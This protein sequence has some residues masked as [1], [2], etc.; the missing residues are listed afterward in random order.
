M[1]Q[2]NS[3]HDRR[4][5]SRIDF[6]HEV[7]LVNPASG[8]AYDGAF[9]DISLQGML[10]HSDPLPKS[11]DHLQGTLLLGD[12]EVIIS[13]VVLWSRGEQGAAI[14][15]H[16]LDLESFSHL[17]RLVTLNIGDSDRVDHELFSAL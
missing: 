14:R 17:R 9:N 10:F 13:G 12:I 16:D 2:P 7:T 15:F 8:Q 4:K 5:F 6:H 11:G 3:N 1:T